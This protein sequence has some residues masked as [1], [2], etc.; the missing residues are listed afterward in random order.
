VS[1]A[2]PSGQTLASDQAAVFARYGRVR[3]HCGAPA[4]DVDHLT[5]IGAGGDDSLANL[6]PSCARC[7]RGW[8]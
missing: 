4:T 8:R 7:N 6:R 1:A 3:V 5:P 2:P